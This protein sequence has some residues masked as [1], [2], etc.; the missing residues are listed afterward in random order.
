MVDDPEH[1]FSMLKYLTIWG[2]F[3]SEIGVTKELAKHTREGMWEG[4]AELPNVDQPL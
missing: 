4:C 2:Y 3:T 1:W